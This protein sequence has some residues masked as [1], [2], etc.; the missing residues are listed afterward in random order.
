MKARCES[1]ECF[2]LAWLSRGGKYDDQTPRTWK[3]SGGGLE[4]TAYP[5]PWAVE[6]HAEGHIHRIALTYSETRFGG[7]RPW[8]SCPHCQKRRRVLHYVQKS[9]VCRA[10][11]DLRYTSE[12][13][14]VLSRAA[15]QRRRLMEKVGGSD[16]GGDFPLKPKGMHWKTYRAIEAKAQASLKAFALGVARMGP[17]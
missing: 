7:R 1:Y 10:C 6:L 13:E 3:Y 12:V 4:I 8:L 11:F 17:R 14:D 9:F 15:R 5:G 16:P 2:D